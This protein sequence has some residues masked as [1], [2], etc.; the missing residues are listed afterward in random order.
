MTRRLLLVE[1]LLLLLLIG[2]GAL[3]ADDASPAATSASEQPDALTATLPQPS[4]T[5]TLIPTLTNFPP[6]PTVTSPPEPTPVT[7]PAIILFI[8][9]GMGATHRQAATWAAFGQDGFLMMDMLP[10]HGSAQTA[11]T[12]GVITDSAA[13][14]TSI[15][16][17]VVTNSQAVGVDEFGNSVGTILELAKARGWSV[18]LVS[19]T[20]LAHATPAAFAAHVP[21]RGARGE[22]A[23]QI[24]ARGVDV[25]LGGGE[26]DFF[27]FDRP[28]AHFDR[29]VGA[30][31]G[32]R[33]A[34][35]GRD[36]ERLCDLPG[37][38][39]CGYRE[40]ADPD[41]RDD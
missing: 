16:S 38:G 21:N 17:G 18:G 30:L 2:C 12:T 9:D 10:V 7:T 37:A 22:I 15:A 20:S 5:F 14:A 6:T 23:R 32:H 35:F 27:A 41:R 31:D 39:E 1:L 25:L 3:S 36:F 13:S 29:Q 28:D 40:S 11:T 24:M 26:D 19:T 4:A 33:R 8:G 34:D